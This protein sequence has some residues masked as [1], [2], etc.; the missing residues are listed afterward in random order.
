MSDPDIAADT[1]GVRRRWPGPYGMRPPAGTSRPAASRAGPPRSAASGDMPRPSAQ[2]DAASRRATRDT[3]ISAAWLVA[4]LEAVRARCV[5]RRSPAHVPAGRGGRSGPTGADRRSPHCSSHVTVA[6]G[7]RGAHAR[8]RRAGAAVRRAAAAAG[9]G[10]VH[11]HS[12]SLQE[13]EDP[14][15]TGVARPGRSR[16]RYATAGPRRRR[17]H[18]RRARRRR[19]RQGRADPRSGW[20]ELRWR[21]LDDGRALAPRDVG[22]QAGSLVRAL[23]ADRPRAGPRRRDGERPDRLGLPPVLT[24]ALHGRSAARDRRRLPSPRAGEPGRCPATPG[25]PGHL[26]GVGV[27]PSAGV[28]RAGRDV[29]RRT[30]PC[31]WPTRTRRRR[32]RRRS[33]AGMT[34]SFIQNEPTAR[35]RSG[36]ASRPLRRAR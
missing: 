32:R 28:E 20:P 16:R 17:G 21:Q 2:H 34:V 30:A 29:G 14:A 12:A 36:T 4:D 35:R 24:D 6:P 3:W 8:I 10:A 19:S 27:R 15:V 7:P 18:A 31:R 23:G 13:A 22:P 1:F 11:R 25:R 26:D 33:T 5:E 9:A